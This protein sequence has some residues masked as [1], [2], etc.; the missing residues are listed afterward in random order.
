[1]NTRLATVSLLVGALMLPVASVAG[2]KDK[3]Q[4]QDRSSPKAFLKDSV[5]TAKVKSEFAR[6]KKVSALHIKVDTD[7]S[8]IVQLSGTARSQD[9]AD[10]A[11]EIAKRVKGVVLV[12]SDIKV[13]SER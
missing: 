4:D 2:D 7:D 1:M 6:D 5:I 13:G 9:E 11:I 10:R 12:Q 8:G 3:A